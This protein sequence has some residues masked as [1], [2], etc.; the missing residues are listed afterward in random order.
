MSRRKRHCSPNGLTTLCGRDCSE[1]TYVPTL[2]WDTRVM[3]RRCLACLAKRPVV[4][5]ARP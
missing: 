2:S 4:A 1:V 3:T 5:A